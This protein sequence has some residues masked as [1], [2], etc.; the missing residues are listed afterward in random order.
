MSD[1]VGTKKRPKAVTLQAG[2]FTPPSR[3]PWGGTQLVDRYKAGLDLPGIAESPRVVGESWELCVGPEFPSHTTDGASLREVITGNP[4]P[5]LGG[6]AAQGSTSLLVK[7]IDTADNLS[8]QIHP[9]DAYAKLG[10][11][12]GGKPECWY[13][14]DAKPEAG[15]YLGL[16]E[17]TDL[18]AMRQ[19]I[20]SGDDVSRLLHFV[21]VAPGDFF[22]IDAGTPHAIGAGLTLV[23]PQRV[24]PGRKGITYRYWDWNR[25]YD[26]DGAPSA[27]GQLRQLHIEEALEVTAW[28]RARGEP[29]IQQIA[30]RAGPALINGQAT[31]HPLCGATAPLPSP[32]FS[33][34]RV[35]GSGRVDLPIRNRLH[36]L[37]VIEG[38]VTI[39]HGNGGLNLR[40]GQSAALPAAL[41]AVSLKLEGTHAILCAVA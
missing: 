8:V 19:A 40:A 31:V 1:S 18:L 35:V 17:N 34:D 29:L 21:S 39:E 4:A 25:R 37:V 38:R 7:W 13:V 14:V 24:M 12:E 20:D 5:W 22:L 27:D 16:A 26:P 41:G 33:V 10:P 15:I 30:N 32:N 11:D 28:E 6:E 23:E 36:A 3:T 2:N 9:T